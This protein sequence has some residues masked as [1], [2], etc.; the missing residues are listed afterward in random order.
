MYQF[1]AWG[2]YWA[3][4]RVNPAGKVLEIVA[5]FEDLQEAIT[6]MKGYRTE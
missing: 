4:V 2:Q 5:R 1:R 3:I 6:A